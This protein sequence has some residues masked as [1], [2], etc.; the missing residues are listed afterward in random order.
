MNVRIQYPL[1]FTAGIYYNNQM[2]MNHYVAKLYMMT[3]TPDS[4]ANN[5]A[6]DRIKH[7]VYNE[8]DSSIF[9]SSECEEQCKK[10]LDADLK[11]TTFPGDPVDQLVGIMLFCKLSAIMEGR[12]IMGEVELSSTLSDGLI[13]IHSDNENIDDLNPPAWWDS[14]DLIHCDGD[15]INTDKIV[16]MHHGS[17]W[18]DLDLQWPDIEDITEE[19]EEES[20]NTVVFAD[21]KRLDEKE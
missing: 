5:V 18:R 2:Q 17:V 16:T 6:F 3:N 8:L 19:L 7:F 4:A 15:L 14:V 9:I 11:I 21:F 10:Y 20:G 12:I 1:N 13:Y